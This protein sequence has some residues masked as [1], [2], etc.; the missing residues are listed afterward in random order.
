MRGDHCVDSTFKQLDEYG[1]DVR[2]SIL[3]SPRDNRQPGKYKVDE[4]SLFVS[5]AWHMS[6]SLDVLLIDD[7]PEVC[8]AVRAMLPVGDCKINVLQVEPFKG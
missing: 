6:Q 1:L 2:S 3:K 8:S 7:S 5:A 4:I